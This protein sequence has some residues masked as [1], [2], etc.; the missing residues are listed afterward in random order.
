MVA[1]AAQTILCS[2]KDYTGIPS[3]VKGSHKKMFV[4]GI[5]DVVHILQ[6]FTQRCSTRYFPPCFFVFSLSVQPRQRAKPHQQS[7]TRNKQT[8]IDKGKRLIG[9]NSNLLKVSNLLSYSSDYDT[10]D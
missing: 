9:L 4:V 7:L 8:A 1:L 3:Q 10:N 2:N 6:Q 5:V